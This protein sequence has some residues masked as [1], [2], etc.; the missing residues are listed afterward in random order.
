MAGASNAQDGITISFQNMKSITLSADKKIASIQPGNIWGDVYRELT[1]SDLNVI[2]GRIYDIGV[3]GLT[4]GGTFV[5]E[6]LQARTYCVFFFFFWDLNKNICGF[7]T[8]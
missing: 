3:G 8:A 1:K 7:L 6:T 2:G 5:I 4:T